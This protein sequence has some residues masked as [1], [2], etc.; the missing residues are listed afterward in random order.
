LFTAFITFAGFGS[1]VLVIW[2]GARLVE[3]G[4]L[5]FGDLT[6]FLMYTMF[7]SGAIGGFVRLYG[8]LQRAIGA[9]QRVRELL[10]ET[11][12]ETSDA[13]SAAA[14]SDGVGQIAGDIAFE[15]IT[16]AYPSR[17]E[18]PILRNLSLV[19]KAGQRIALVGPS[20]AGKSTFVSLLLRFF[21]PDA[22][23]VLRDCPEVWLWDVA[24]GKEKATLRGHTAAVYPVAF[25]GDGKLLASGSADGTVR[26]W[27]V[28]TGKEKAVLKAGK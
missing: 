1:I 8:E 12:E 19:A 11:P 22:G 15:D 3:E 10:Q 9:T 5:T 20:G 21:D 2:Y 23:R 28:A 25:S 13:A 7:V 6:Q 27:D 16:F 24:T 4:A 26:L 18:V 17:K 14:R